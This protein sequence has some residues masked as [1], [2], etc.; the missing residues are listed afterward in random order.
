MSEP[1]QLPDCLRE[2]NQAL[3]YWY[4][5]GTDA[6][7]EERQARQHL[8]E[9]RDKLQAQL[10]KP[11][12]IDDPG[13]K[14]IADGFKFLIDNGRSVEAHPGE[15][16]EVFLVWKNTDWETTARLSNHAAC[17]TVMALMECIEVTRTMQ[18]KD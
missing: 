7:T 6:S 18:P 3:N 13:F 4:P 15:R 10:R 12:A 14:P 8:F 16:G 1:I 17:L 5:G 11:P 9:F 2:I